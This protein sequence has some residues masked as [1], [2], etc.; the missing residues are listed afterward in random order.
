MLPWLLEVVQRALYT[1][2]IVYNMNPLHYRWYITCSQ[3]PPF[4][5]IINEGVEP[6]IQSHV[7]ILHLY[8]MDKAVGP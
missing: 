1:S 2:S 8:G 3:A 5:K 7:S 6:V 4:K